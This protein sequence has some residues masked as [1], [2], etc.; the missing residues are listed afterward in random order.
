MITTD[1]KF[2]KVA[3]GHRATEDGRYAVVVDGYTRR[4]TED[5]QDFDGV[6]GREWAACFDPKGR[7]REAHNAGD[8]IDWFD[9]MADAIEACQRHAA[10]VA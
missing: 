3:P 7:L 2:T 6:R 4:G 9:R 5:Q 10:E 8:N 1:L